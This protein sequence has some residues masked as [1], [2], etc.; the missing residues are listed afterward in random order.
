MTLTSK[1][2]AQTA[3]RTDQRIR[4][5]DEIISGVHVIK[6]YAWEVPFSQLVAVARRL[7]LKIIRKTSFVRGLYMTFVLFT[8]RAAV[9]CTM[10]AIVI[11]YGAHEITAEKVFVMSLYYTIIALTMNQFFVR[12]IAEIAEVLVALR[13]L[14]HFLEL[15][16]KQTESITEQLSYQNVAVAT[17]NACATWKM[18]ASSSSSQSKAKQQ[19]QADEKDNFYKSESP[20]L[21]NINVE[22]PRGKLIGVIGPVGAGKSSFLQML[23]RELPL[24]SGT[25]TING[26][27]SYANQEPWVFAA[28]VRQNILFGNAYEQNRYNE[29]VKVCA[30]RPDFEQFENGDLSIVGEKGS[31][32][33]GQ[34]ARIKYVRDKRWL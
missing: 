15:E 11:L 19:T 20:T 14:Q 31:L 16:E 28:S 30:L 33:G 34:K 10:L 18:P 6:M 4:F 9:F 25:L 24:D 27:V 13:R 12:G 2:R 7:E 29:I 23:L 5:M 17:N 32:S 22:F 8:T 1:F 26:S 3:L 21:S